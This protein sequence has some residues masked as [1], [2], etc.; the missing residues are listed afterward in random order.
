MASRSAVLVLAILVAVPAREASAARLI[1]LLGGSPLRWEVKAK[2]HDNP[3][4]LACCHHLLTF[5][6]R[7]RCY[8]DG[9]GSCPVA[10]DERGGVSGTFV[11]IQGTSKATSL[12]MT[13]MFGNGAVCEFAGS[14]D[15]GAGTYSCRDAAGTL[16][17]DDAFTF[18]T[19]RCYRGRLCA[20]RSPCAY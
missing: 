16:E 6:G 8:D 11:V 7:I 1:F 20:T 14:V 10:A 9:T 15:A 4:V 12:R 3:N 17:R 5:S 13:A 2:V 18:G 19:C